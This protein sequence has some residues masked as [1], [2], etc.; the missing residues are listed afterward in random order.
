MGKM[1]QSADNNNNNNNNKNNDDNNNKCFL[2]D[3]YF[4]NWFQVLYSY[5]YGCFG[6][7]LSGFVLSTVFSYIS[8]LSIRF[9]IEIQHKN[10][11]N[12][13]FWGK[14]SLFRMC[15]K[16]TRPLLLNKQLNWSHHTGQQLYF[17][18]HFIILILYY[19]IYFYK[20]D[21]FIVI[22]CGM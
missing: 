16:L 20:H 21:S 2:I 17:Y 3:K 15:K 7:K 11:L 5:F 8:Y 12:N 18:I 19:F 9:L 13:V 10:I 6:L 14:I 1:T 4:N 22:D